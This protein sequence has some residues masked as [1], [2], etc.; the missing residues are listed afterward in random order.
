MLSTPIDLA[1]SQGFEPWCPFGLLLSKQVYL[2]ALP[3]LHEDW[4]P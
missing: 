2:T 4:S 1:E 3:A